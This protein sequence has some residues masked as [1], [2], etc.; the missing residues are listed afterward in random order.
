MTRNAG[1]LLVALALTACGGGTDTRTEGTGD[2]TG[3]TMIV[4]STSEP[5]TLFPPR[6][7]SAQEQAVVASVFDRLAEIGP[8]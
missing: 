3:G 4:V 7:I 1:A 2:G 8:D 6:A 5:G